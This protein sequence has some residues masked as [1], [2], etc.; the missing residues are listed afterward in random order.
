M[1]IEDDLFNA[2]K[3]FNLGQKGKMPVGGMLATL[4][5]SV[6]INTLRGLQQKVARMEGEIEGVISKL[7]K[8]D[9]GTSAVPDPFTVLGV[10]PSA[11]KEEVTEAYRKKAAKVHPDKGGSN[12]QMILVNAAFEAI[13]RFRGWT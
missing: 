13:R 9:V 12:E 6:Q 8:Q 2:L 1:G 10:T 3:Y 4:I 7:S 5:R 11:T